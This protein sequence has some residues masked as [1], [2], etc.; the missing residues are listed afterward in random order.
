MN[1]PTSQI[2]KNRRKQGAASIGLGIALGTALGAA[3]GNVALGLII[4]ILIGGM[5]AVSRIKRF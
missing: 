2:P 4:G 1:N 5:G 3:L